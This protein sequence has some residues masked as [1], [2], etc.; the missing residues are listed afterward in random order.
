VNL[1][2]SQGVN[3]KKT[4]LSIQRKKTPRRHA[5]HGPFLWEINTFSLQHDGFNDLLT[6]LKKT[7]P[8]APAVAF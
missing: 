2:S 4:K 3:P 1:K 8:A 6:V 5:A 7:N